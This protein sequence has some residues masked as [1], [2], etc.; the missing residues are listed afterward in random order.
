MTHVLPLRTGW[1]PAPD[2]ADDYPPDLP[3]EW[4][5]AYFANDFWGVLVPA[6]L[7]R[8]AGPASLAGWAAETPA[9]FRFFLDLGQGDLEVRAAAAAAALGDRFGGLV[10]TPADLASVPE[11]GS[12][13]LLRVAA[14]PGQTG[15][16][17]GWGRAWEV[18]PALIRGDLRG[19]RGWVDA[20][21]RGQGLQGV[22]AEAI[23]QVSRPLVVLLGPCRFEDLARW[24]AMLELM[25]LA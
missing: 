9:R 6:G 23:P 7:W 3:P 5:L 22:E 4:R 17:A 24:Q 8:A 21:V 19:A 1:A 13:C 20:K 11:A 10:G 14:E 15:P 12:V 18:P 2:A 16:L 25:G